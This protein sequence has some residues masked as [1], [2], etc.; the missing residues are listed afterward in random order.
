[1]T[2]KSNDPIPDGNDSQG[3]PAPKPDTK[4]EPKP[5]EPLGEGG[6][7]ALNAERDAR[8]VAEKA[9]AEAQK[10]LDAANKQLADVKN[11][12]LPEWQQKFN[13]LQAKLD[14]E[15]TAREKAEADAQTATLAQ[16]RSDRAAAKGLP[17]ALAKKLTGS[18]A[19]DLDAEI[20]ELLPLL[21]ASAPKPNPQQGSP[22]Q[23]RGGS[24]SAGRER[25]AATHK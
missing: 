7:K 6:I 23:S 19:D 4:L 25:Y 11:D 17:A 9:T 2:D 5:D 3:D 12:G 1:M 21:G 10:Q 13:D 18:T 8:K 16:M 24:L 14:G 20:D 22:S 15:I